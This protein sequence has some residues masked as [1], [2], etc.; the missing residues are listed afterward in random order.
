MTTTVE[1]L[2]AWILVAGTGRR[3]QMHAAVAITARELGAAMAERGCGLVTGG[4][5]G[6]DHVVTNAFAERC[7]S[8]GIDPNRRLVQLVRSDYDV[9]L[10]LGQIVRVPVGVEE[11]LTA[12]NYADATVFLGGSGGTYK[13]FLGALHRGLPR[14]PLAGTRGDAAQAYKQMVELWELIP[15]PGMSIEQFRALGPRIANADDAKGIV[16]ATI[17]LVLA[18][19]QTQREQQRQ[20]DLPPEVFIGYATEDREWMK[21]LR[22]VLRPLE[23]Q[24]L[25]R[26]WSD[27]DV[28][29]GNDRAA[30]VTAKSESC[31]IAVLLVSA[32]LLSSDDPTVA[33]MTRLAE[34]AMKNE[35]RLLWVPLG[36]SLWEMTPLKRLKAVI[37]TNIS[38]TQMDQAQ[39]QVALVEIAREVM[40]AVG[41]GA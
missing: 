16:K 23:S 26:F 36:P 2:A 32:N 41:G 21:R 3:D 37:D 28:F 5:Y 39:V 30:E 40:R 35:V 38:L 12:H 14:F 10:Q 9:Q 22:I 11:W 24:N 6:V 1:N 13:T 4:W 25:L 20:K 27:M 8:L 15:N 33:C 17:D 34:R 7:S 18:S 31:A 29:P 19:I